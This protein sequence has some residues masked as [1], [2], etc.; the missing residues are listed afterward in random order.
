[1]SVAVSSDVSTSSDKTSADPQHDSSSREPRWPYLRRNLALSTSDG[2]A[3]GA[4]VG[5]GET[6]LPAFAL[7]LGMGE[8]MAGL[9]ASVPLLVGGILQCVSLRAINRL[10]SFKLW[11]A[12]SAALQGL[13]LVPLVVAAMAGSLSPTALLLIASIYWAGGLAAGPAWNTWIGHLVPT[14]VRSRFF[15]KRTRISQLMTLGGFLAGGLLLQWVDRDWVLVAFAAIFTAACLFRLFS[16]A[17]LLAHQ[18]SSETKALVQRLAAAQ[19]TLPAKLEPRGMRLIA[20]L[21]AVQGMVQISGPY[22]T[23]YMIKQ[24]HFDYGQYVVL[25]ATAFVAK[26]LSLIL[27]GNVAGTKGAR[28]L[29]WVGGISII[30]L[31][32]LWTLSESFWWVVCVQLLSGTTWAAYELGFFLMFFE[33]M[34]VAQRARMLTIYNV[35][36]TCAWCVG[37]LIGGCILAAMGP[38]LQSYWTIFGL[39][40]LGRLF[41]LGLLLRVDAL[42]IPTPRKLKVAWRI[43]GVRP[44]SATIST[45]VLATIEAAETAQS[46]TAA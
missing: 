27:W 43:I 28:F 44:S 16:A 37:S 23:P 41:A 21:V 7:A 30:P 14:T 2:A 40:S 10:G 1:M 12:C 3:Y 24:L 17:M 4:M 32:S 15:A 45:P 29:L 8:V 22:F 6:Y 42:P 5:M 33:S 38:S 11:I 34:P 20:Y 19:R 35:A 39:S 46:K 9:V 13:S 36:N 25:V 18:E 26:A 31:A